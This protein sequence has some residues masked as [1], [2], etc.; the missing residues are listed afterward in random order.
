MIVVIVFE[1]LIESMKLWI[2]VG[3]SVYPKQ[4]DDLVLEK[5]DITVLNKL[6]ELKTEFYACASADDNIDLFML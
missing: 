6:Y 1:K 3:N 2:Q 5:Y 4:D